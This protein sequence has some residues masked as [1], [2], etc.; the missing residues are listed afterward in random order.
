[1]VTSVE[2]SGYAAARQFGRLQRCIQDL[3]NWLGRVLRDIDRKRNNTVFSVS[4]ETLIARHTQ[5]GK[6]GRRRRCLCCGVIRIN[7]ENLVSAIAGVA[8]QFNIRQLAKYVKVVD[9]KQFFPEHQTCSRFSVSRVFTIL[10][11]AL[12]SSFFMI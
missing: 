3:K 10:G 9:G 4:F 5:H 6:T 7:P 8:V 2:A 11:S 1:M 12:P